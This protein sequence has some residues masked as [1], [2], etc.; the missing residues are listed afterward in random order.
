[1]GVWIPLKS[2]K[3]QDNAT[4]SSKEFPH[5]QAIMEYGFTMKRV[6][7]MIRFYSQLHHR[8]KYSQHSSIIWRGWLNDWVFIYKPSDCGFCCSHLNFRY[9][10]CFENGVIW[11]SG[12]Y[13][14]WIHSETRTWHDK[15][16]Q[17]KL[18]WLILESI[19][20]LEI[21]TSKLFNLDFANNTTSLW[22]SFSW[23][24]T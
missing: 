23:L 19:K 16:M 17:W 11:H 22:F 1:M 9:G 18:S 3:P 12:I 5:S 8:D 10:A 6:L 4:V 15:N 24:L 21:K 20:A 2:F 7:D 14:V 13:R